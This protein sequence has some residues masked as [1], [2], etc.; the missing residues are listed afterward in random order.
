[1]PLEE[2]PFYDVVDPTA[3]ASDSDTAKASSASTIGRSA[4]GESADDDSNAGNAGNDSSAAASDYQDD[5]DDDQYNH[6]RFVVLPGGPAQ[7]IQGAPPSQA[8]AALTEEEKAAKW[9]AVTYHQVKYADLAQANAEA[10]DF[11]D[12][13]Q[14]PEGGKG[15]GRP[16]GG[17]GRYFP[18]SAV[19]GGA[20]TASARKTPS[21]PFELPLG[22]IYGRIRHFFG[23]VLHHDP[24]LVEVLQC[25]KEV[26]EDGRA[27]QQTTFM[28]RLRNHAKDAIQARFT[29]NGPPPAAKFPSRGQILAARLLDAQ[30]THSYPVLLAFFNQPEQDMLLFP[31]EE[32]AHVSL[33]QMQKIETELRDLAAVTKEVGAKINVMA[34]AV[35]TT[36][37][38][39]DV[40]D[41]TLQ[42]VRNAEARVITRLA[43]Q[44]RH[45]KT[46]GPPL[47]AMGL[48]PRAT[49]SHFAASMPPRTATPGMKTPTPAGRTTARTPLLTSKPSKRKATS[50]ATAARQ[51]PAPP[52]PPADDSFEDDD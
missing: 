46:V 44:E 24:L 29:K 49:P 14:L 9:D 51:P 26:Y 35:A 48:T 13:V 39:S 33:P 8:P 1:M 31:S 5:D 10:Q 37:Q 2:D 20:A 15:R 3:A 28:R 38:L 25:A 12:N 4:A 41:V 32:A 23:P 47:Q 17:Q 11:F 18:A 43:D 34:G 21:K 22:E 45:Q 50:P 16:R 40:H 30:C 6:D 19:A 27:L 36:Q 42:V 7:G 52:A